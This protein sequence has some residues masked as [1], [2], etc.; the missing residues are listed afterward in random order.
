MIRKDSGSSFR[1]LLWIIH[2]LLLDHWTHLS[3]KWT[4]WLNRSSVDL[5]ADVSVDGVPSIRNTLPSSCK[6]YS[7]RLWKRNSFAVGFNLFQ[8]VNVIIV[9]DFINN[10]KEWISPAPVSVPV[11]HNKP[12]VLLIDRSCTVIIMWSVSVWQ[13]LSVSQV[14]CLSIWVE[15]LFLT[16][17]RSQRP[18]WPANTKGTFLN[19]HSRDQSFT[20]IPL[21]TGTL[22]SEGFIVH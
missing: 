11:G 18:C 2:S 22:Q 19:C 16:C 21:L 4:G 13:I 5:H 14:E 3:V 1:L 8:S 9:R 20:S 7:C 12:N 10:V 17:V 6:A 15:L